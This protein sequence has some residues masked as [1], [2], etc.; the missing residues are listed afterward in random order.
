MSS[1]M[2]CILV[3]QRNDTIN[4]SIFHIKRWNTCTH[5]W[6]AM[7][8]PTSYPC[9]PTRSPSPPDP[10]FSSWWMISYQR[11]IQSKL[12]LILSHCLLIP[13]CSLVLSL[14]F[15]TGSMVFVVVDIIFIIPEAHLY[16]SNIL[17]PSHFIHFNLSLFIT[18]AIFFD[19]SPLFLEYIF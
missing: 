5:L 8:W 19:L 10:W 9:S 14:S 11:H 4:D 15:A 16:L 13:C 18:F 1:G 7:Q 2:F 12:S 3:I 6:L 17:S